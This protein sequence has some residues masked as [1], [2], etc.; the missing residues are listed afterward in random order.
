MLPDSAHQIAGAAI[1]EKEK[2]LSE[3]PERRRSKVVAACLSLT[4]AVG[5]TASHVMKGKVRV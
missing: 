1:M 4:D 3:P 2:A 5:E